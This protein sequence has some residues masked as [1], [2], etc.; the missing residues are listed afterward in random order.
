MR[1]IVRSKETNLWLPIPLFL[2]NTAVL[3]LP[4]SVIAEIKKSLPEPYQEVITKKFLQELVREC[5]S[6]LKQYK[7]LEIV[8]V[9]TQDGTFVSIRL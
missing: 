5:Q 7:G 1:I 9:E 2:A 4:E 6:V 3:L 8:H